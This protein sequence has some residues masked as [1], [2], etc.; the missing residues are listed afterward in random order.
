MTIILDD[1][2]KEGLLGC[3]KGVYSIQNAFIQRLE[4]FIM[5]RQPEEEREEDDCP[6]NAG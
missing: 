5:E 3:S 1:F 2:V 4:K 6:V